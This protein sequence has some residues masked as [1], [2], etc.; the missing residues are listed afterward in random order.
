MEADPVAGTAVGWDRDVDRDRVS[1]EQA[2]QGGGGEVG[3]Q[4]ALA[5]G[6]H[7]GEPATVLREARAADEIDAT[8]DA[9]QASF[10]DPAGKRRGADARS[11]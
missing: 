11:S 1:F 9:V 10:A 4:G 7:G 8:V 2:V 6:E 5:G 3:E